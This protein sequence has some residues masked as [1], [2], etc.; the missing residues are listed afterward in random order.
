MFT[1]KFDTDN[2]AFC[3]GNASS[4]VASILRRVASQIESSRDGS[5]PVF[6]SNGNRVGHWSLS[7][8]AEQ[9]S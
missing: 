4:E 8:L 9:E 7:I 6:D 5:R 1:L 3:E 2:A